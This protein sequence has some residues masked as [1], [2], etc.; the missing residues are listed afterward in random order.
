MTHGIGQGAFMELQQQMLEKFLTAI[1]IGYEF[2]HD[3]F[4]FMGES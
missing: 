3:A 1:G 4:P 2:A